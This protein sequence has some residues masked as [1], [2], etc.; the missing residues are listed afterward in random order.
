MLRLIC[1][2]QFVRRSF[3]QYVG[4]AVNH[5]TNDLLGNRVDV[6]EKHP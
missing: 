1:L 3:R 2:M 4:P 5:R 6:E